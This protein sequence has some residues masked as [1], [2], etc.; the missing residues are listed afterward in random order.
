MFNIN[1]VQNDS[2]DSVVCGSKYDSIL[3]SKKLR[4]KYESPTHIAGKIAP[5][6]IF[7]ANFTKLAP[8]KAK[9]SSN[10]TTAIGAVQHI[11]HFY[12]SPS[13]ILTYFIYDGLGQAEDREAPITKRRIVRPGLPIL[14][15][16]YWLN[17][18]V[19]K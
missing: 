1:Y 19:S 11:E 6:F 5:R 18:P 17:A 2:L 15:F 14:R 3:L 16:V 10:C 7:E 13:Y 9:I 4:N 8:T 12:S